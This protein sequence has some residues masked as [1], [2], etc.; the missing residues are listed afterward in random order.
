M[1]ARVN[2]AG[3]EPCPM[4]WAGSLS[5]PNNA[6]SVIPTFNWTTGPAL[7]PHEQTDPIESVSRSTSTWTSISIS[8]S[9]SSP[10]NSHSSPT[11][12][13]VD[14]PRTE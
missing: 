2:A 7:P 11:L 13:S 1:I 8:I 3:I 9:I 6:R 12:R 4:M 14:P 10:G 5:V